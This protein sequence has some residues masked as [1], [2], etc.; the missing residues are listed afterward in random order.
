MIIFDN[1]NLDEQYSDEDLKEMALE[2]GWVDEDTDIT[3]EMMWEWRYDLNLDDWEDTKIELADFFRGKVVGFFGTVG[4]WN[5]TFAGGKIG[6]FWDVYYEAIKDCGY[7]K[8][9]DK[10][11]HL[12][13]TC[14]HHDGTN[15]FEIKEITEK[16]LQYLRNWEFSYDNRTVSQCYGQIAKR[17][18]R[19]PRYARAV[20]GC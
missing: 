19:L 1:Y 12:Y 20:Y 14:S 15:H 7:I 4:R 5:G 11:G 8:I 18:S 6:E 16:G 13:L 2:C 17:Y 3:D 10:G 9:E